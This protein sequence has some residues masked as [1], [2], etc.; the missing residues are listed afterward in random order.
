[1]YFVPDFG[2][3]ATVTRELS[4]SLCVFVR[5]FSHPFILTESGCTWDT[6]D[7][8]IRPRVGIG[9]PSPLWKGQITIWRDGYQQRACKESLCR[10]W[11]R[12]ISTWHGQFTEFSPSSWF[13]GAV[14]T[15][16]AQAWIA[17]SLGHW[18]HVRLTLKTNL[19]SSSSKGKR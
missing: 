13:R 18:R 7:G 5:R 2:C 15:L 3:L 4:V 17:L 9:Q 10:I 16:V 1:L 12:R 19:D 8:T 6:H 14:G 11:R